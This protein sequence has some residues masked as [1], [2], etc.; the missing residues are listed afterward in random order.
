MRVVSA[1]EP[2]EQ[3]PELPDHEKEDDAMR[4][5]ELND[6]PRGGSVYRMAILPR[7][8]RR[9]EQQALIRSI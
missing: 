3:A 1:R 7:R 6:I 2:F 9:R 5:D 4:A 8:R